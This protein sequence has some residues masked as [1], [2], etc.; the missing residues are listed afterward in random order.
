M[1]KSKVTKCDFKNE[2][3]TSYGTFYNFD[4]SFEDGTQGM[5]ASKDKN[6]PK[7]KV[8]ETTEYE[9]E[10]KS[11]VKDG[12]EWSFNKIKPVKEFNAGGG[13]YKQKPA[14]KFALEL[15]RKMY[16]SSQNTDAKWDVKGMLTTATWILGKINNG[17]DRDAIETATTIEGA[18]AMNKE[19]TDSKRLGTN[20]KETEKWL[21]ENQ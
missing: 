4:V 18:Y 1:A 10:V 13:G 14:N 8:G 11:G 21:K 3:T 12:K 9:I 15:S 2:F 6:S 17:V 16:N 19:R 20:I 7:F 5:Y